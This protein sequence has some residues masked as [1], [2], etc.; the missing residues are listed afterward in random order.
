MVRSVSSPAERR[1]F[2]I[3]P[4]ETGGEAPRR[5]LLPRALLRG[6][7]AERAFAAGLALP[8]A[9]GPIRFTAMEIAER[10]AGEKGS[11]RPLPLS[12]VMSRVFD[13]A[14]GLSSLMD[15]L[16]VPRQAWAG[17]EL[18]K[19]LIMGVVN[20]TPDSFSDGGDFAT[21]QTA[22]AQGIRLA[23]H[24]ADIVD[25]GGESTRPGAREISAE[26]ELARTIPVVKTLAERGLVVSID[27]RHATVMTAAV[28]GGARIIN[29]ITALTGDPA[30]V[31]AAA[32]SNAAIV[33]MH[34]QGE[35]RTMQADPH[36][37]D[38]T[39]DLL[40]YFDERL[41]T[42]EKAGIDPAR[43]VIDPGIGFGKKD[44]HNM[45]LLSELAAFQVFGCAVLLGVS[46]KSFV[47]RLSRK[48][49]PKERMAGSL[50]AGLAGFDQGVQII[51]VHDVAETY[52]ARAIWQAIGV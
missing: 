15:G 17:F 21:P 28:A 20:V 11:R 1:G 38:T 52:Q 37:A 33:L 16:M 47:G 27:T 46:R 18:A 45:L 6:A 30:S 5:Y 41:Q 42:L 12:A 34:M 32:R 49:P 29:D 23:E 25:V 51:R 36:Y 10:R 50:A 24:G 14:A 7:A 35:P 4:N 22:I 40:D 13:G 2:S 19:P 26:E 43:I 3:A 48:E 31:A 39:L 9:G 8:L 44:P